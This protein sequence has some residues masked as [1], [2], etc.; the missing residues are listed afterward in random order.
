[1]PKKPDPKRWLH[2]RRLTADGRVL[3]GV[4]EVGRGCLAGPVV[5]AAVKVD[6]A[7]FSS[8]A[9]R[10]VC[11]EMRDSKQ[12][13]ADR[14]EALSA[15]MHAWRSEGILQFA[16]AEASVAEIEQLNILEANTL[17]MRRALT[18]L[19]PEGADWESE[20]APL[21]LI[22]GRPVKRLGFLH[23]AIVKG[24]DKSL[25]IAMASILAKVYRDTLMTEACATF[26]AY[27]FSQNKGYGS[28]VHRK[29][30]KEIG[31]CPL[32]R[33]SFLQKILSDPASNLQPELPL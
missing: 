32:H 30:L 24:D 21:I 22:D 12:L 25:V 7:F 1:M 11:L 2:D 8:R 31:P 20:N 14:R 17:A 19:L 16:I 27:Q 10:A 9:R 4:D 15:E 26:P 29:A 3:L 18:E 13:S 5:A 33:M 23:D 6:E 28:E